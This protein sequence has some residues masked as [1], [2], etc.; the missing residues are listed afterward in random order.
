MKIYILC[1]LL[2]AAI[3]TDH[4]DQVHLEECTGCLEDIDDARDCLRECNDVIIINSDGDTVSR[5]SECLRDNGDFGD[6]TSLDDLSQCCNFDRG[7]END[8]G[9]VQDCLGDCLDIC[10]QE[11]AEEYL[12]CVR[13][14]T[15]TR[16]CE[17]T[18]CLNG[19]LSNDIEDDINFAGSGDIF[20]LRSISNAVAGF[21]EDDLENCLLIKD[22]VDTTC[23]IGRSCCDRCD[24]ELGAMVGC[25][26]NDVVIP[27]VAIEKNTT[28]DTCLIDEQ[29]CE[30][31]E[32]SGRK[33]KEV[34]PEEAELFN[35]ALK[36]SKTN[37]NRQTKRDSRVEAVVA[38]IG[39]RRLETTAEMVAACEDKMRLEVVATNMTHA[40][41][42][43]MECITFAAISSLEDVEEPEEDDSAA[44]IAQF[45]GLALTFATFLFV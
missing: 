39:S 37:S 15:G 12:E 25:I 18:A 35:K 41:N 23:D 32:P 29:D 4:I 20:D 34:S 22:F 6:V 9:D 14:E 5:L 42:N 10:L 7:C 30:F 28:I 45:V 11:D 38:G 33:A 24:S 40:T 17:L 26:V 16:G 13:Q 31:G 3:A 36:L 8:L 21:S 2:G 1:T 19:F 27:F 43:Y 44:A